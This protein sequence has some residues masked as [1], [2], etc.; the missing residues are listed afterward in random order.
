[1]LSVFLHKGWSPE[2]GLVTAAVRNS[3]I[4]LLP[5]L[6]MDRTDQSCLIASSRQQGSI[7]PSSPGPQLVLERDR[8]SLLGREDKIGKTKYV[9]GSRKGKDKGFKS[10]KIQ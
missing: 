2:P 9:F 4:L 10:S 6:G 7:H 8:E 5:V 1:M 3:E